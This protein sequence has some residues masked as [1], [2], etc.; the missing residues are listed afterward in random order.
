MIMEKRLNRDLS[1]PKLLTSDPGQLAM[2]APAVFEAMTASWRAVQA[3]MD[4][5]LLNIVKERV[6]SLLDSDEGCVSMETFSPGEQSI[7]ALVDQFVSRVAEVRES[8]LAGPRGILG[9]IGLR[10]LLETLYVLD[11][12]SRLY[13]S[14]S[15]LF[16]RP[17]L[18]AIPAGLDEPAS[19]IALAQAWHDRALELD[20]LDLLTTE[21]ARLRGAWYHTCRLCAS[22][23][24]IDQGQVVMNTEV[25]D[26]VRA[27]DLE[28]LP[29]RLRSAVKFADAHVIDPRRLLTDALC[30]ELRSVF[31]E[32]E[33][34]EL[35]VDMTA[36]NHQKVTVSLKIE[37]PIRRDALTELFIRADGTVKIGRA[38]R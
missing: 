34:L 8:H 22:V 25:A 35:T 9:D 7:L 33:L 27:G 31:T 23:R 37:P 20:K 32:E 12:L 3:T 30:D 21:A 10:D 5:R 4:V 38:I 11:Q 36:W 24:I 1:P 15:R 17:S 19:L 26:L 16:G 18:R 28:A 29:Q 2:R 6:E 13:W 14:H